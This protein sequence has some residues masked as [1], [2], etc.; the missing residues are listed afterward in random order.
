MRALLCEAPGPAENLV[1]AELPGPTPEPDEVIIRVRTAALNFFDTLLIAGRYQV[2]PALPFSPAAEVSGHVARLG[3]AVNVFRGG[4]RVFA[5]LGWGGARE[6]VA[7]KADRVIAIPEGVG[8]VEAATLHVTYGTTMLALAGRAQLQAGETLAVL[9]ASGGTGQAA[10]EIG[11]LLG[12]R[13]V[14][15]ASSD[16]KLAFCRALGADAGIN[17]SHGD[18]RTA[19]KAVAGKQGVDVIYDSVGG[20]LSEPAFRSLGWNG[21]HLVVGFASGDIPKLPL[22]LPL[23]K[24]ASLIGVYWGEYVKREPHKVRAN[25][26]RIVK[27]VQEGR[28]RPHIHGAYTLEQAADA[29]R[30]IS[31]REVKGKV[32]LVM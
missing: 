30:A 3:S 26:E 9:G 23:L 31:R 7:V 29:F 11:K 22:N 20:E 18:L 2:Q 32:V 19:L 6:E 15:C 5:Y 13:V 28:I 14:A 17:T 21:R 27:W 24:G 10:I 12:A 25:M 16:D 8:E 1:I 4:E